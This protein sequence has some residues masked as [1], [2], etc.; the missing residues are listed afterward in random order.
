MIFGYLILIYLKGRRYI[1]I[2]LLLAL[3]FLVELISTV[4]YAVSDH[5]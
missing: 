3:V 4:A 2:A 1:F 5:G